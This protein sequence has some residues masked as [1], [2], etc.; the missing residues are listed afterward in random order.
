[1][2]ATLVA[3]ALDTLPPDAPTVTVASDLLG[4]I[5][6]PADALY[7]FPAGLYGFDAATRWALVPAGREG[8]CW[9]QS[10]ERAGLVFLLAD[11]FHFFP[12]YE[13]E[14]P[15]DEL[16]KLG[17]TPGARPGVLA[18][19]T[20]PGTPAAGA[21]DGAASVNLRAPIVLDPDARRGRQIVLLDERLS[22][23]EPLALG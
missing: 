13:A 21:A 9:L 22:V 11:P 5:E 3:P 7:T 6:L 17:L 15:D 4:A 2:T 12:A 10:A 20:L 18:I 16:A 1:M 8:L 23:R 14:L 19:V